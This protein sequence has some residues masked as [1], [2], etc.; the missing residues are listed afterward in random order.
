[1]MTMT[2]TRT[3][4]TLPD[5]DDDDD[6]DDGDHLCALY[7]VPG[8]SVRVVLRPSVSGPSRPLPQRRPRR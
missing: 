3:I 2:T 8:D 4:A 5:D 6:D 1:M 7:R